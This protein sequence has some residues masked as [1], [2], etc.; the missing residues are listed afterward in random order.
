MKKVLLDGDKISDLGTI[1]YRK[2]VTE[3]KGNVTPKT[4]KKQPKPKAKKPV[5]TSKI[6]ADFDINTV[7]DDSDLVISKE[8]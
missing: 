1:E 7:I 5:I 8:E 4:I 2:Y 3:R 6:I